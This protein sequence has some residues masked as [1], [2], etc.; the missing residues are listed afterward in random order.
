[1]LSSFPARGDG[2][3]EQQQLDLFADFNG[4]P[5]EF[6]QRVDFYQHEAHL[7]GLQAS[8]RYAYDVIIGGAEAT[9]GTNEFTT[10][11]LTGSG[12]VRFI[13]FGDSG[14]G[15]SAQQELASRMTADSFDL[16]IHAGDVAYGTADGVGGGSYAQYDSWVFGVYAPWHRRGPR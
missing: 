7:G 12:S 14:V 3:P 11:P 10:A 13:A 8:T 5:E 6:E 15:T 4:L 2:Q 16:A 1:M 9:T